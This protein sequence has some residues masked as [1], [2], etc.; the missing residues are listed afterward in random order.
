MSKMISIAMGLFGKIRGNPK[1][2]SLFGALAAAG[3]AYFGIDPNTVA[4]VL[5]PVVRMLRGM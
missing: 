1:K 2:S 3:A 5:E 4:D